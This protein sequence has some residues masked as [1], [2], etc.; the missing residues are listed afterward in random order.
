[1]RLINDN[2]GFIK[3]IGGLN[4]KVISLDDKFKEIQEFNLQCL[5]TNRFFNC[6]SCGSKKINYLPLNKYSLG[7]DD[8]PYK[9]NPDNQNPQAFVNGSNV[10]SGRVSN[11]NFNSPNRKNSQNKKVNKPLMKSHYKYMTGKEVFT[12][13]VAQQQHFEKR[14]L[15]L[16]IENNKKRI[17][18]KRRRPMTS[19]KRS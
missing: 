14:H 16:E 11:P 19:I 4:K 6:L 12:R 2:D 1:M 3:K 18:I 7:D 17:S 9:V 8:R 13:D 5:V 10:F 15:P